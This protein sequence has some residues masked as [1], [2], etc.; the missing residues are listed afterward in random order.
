MARERAE[1]ELRARVEQLRRDEEDCHARLAAADV[2]ATAFSRVIIWA[3]VE[4]SKAAMKQA[5]ARRV[6]A[7]R[8][9]REAIVAA[10]VGV[11]AELESLKKEKAA[12]GA[13]TVAAGAADVRCCFIMEPSETAAPPRQE[14]ACLDAVRPQEEEDVPAGHA[15]GNVL[16]G[17]RP[18]QALTTSAK[19][20]AGEAPHGRPGQEPQPTPAC[21]ATNQGQDQ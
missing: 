2:T 20:E 12:H 5:E 16:G 11:A 13:V 4:D 3:E 6:D 1:A 9:E 7:E 18:L 19:I 8:R 21:G 14:L 17:E 10:M 15:E